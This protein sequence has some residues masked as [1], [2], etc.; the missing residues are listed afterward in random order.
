MNRKRTAKIALVVILAIVIVGVVA[1]PVFAAL[2][3]THE[4]DHRTVLFEIPKAEG[5]NARSEGH[6]SWL[7]VEGTK[8]ADDTYGCAGNMS[9]RAYLF[10]T[11]GEE[12]RVRV[13]CLQIT[14]TLAPTQRR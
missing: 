5:F 13:S 12:I 3:W 2:L 8:I 7:D 11:S 6:S 4:W 14:P 9:A 10:A 1:G